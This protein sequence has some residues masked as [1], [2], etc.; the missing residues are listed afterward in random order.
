MSRPGRRRGTTDRGPLPLAGSLDEVLAGL[1]PRRP[2]GDPAAATAS[3]TAASGAW[4]SVFEHWD[5][6]AGPVLARHARPL[7]IESGTLVVAVDRPPWATQV[8]ALSETILARVAELSVG[9]R[10]AAPALDRLQVV[11]RPWPAGR[12]ASDRSVEE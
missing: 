5:E 6:V 2:R 4:R 12:R 8:Q 10:S 3:V 9:R 7:R 11:V 1:G